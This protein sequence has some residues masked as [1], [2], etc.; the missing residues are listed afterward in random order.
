MWK[1][2]LKQVGRELLSTVVRESGIR[3]FLI[4][5]IKSKLTY[6]IT[7]KSNN[8][9][10]PCITDYLAENH[11]DKLSNIQPLFAMT[12]EEFDKTLIVKGKF[13]IWHNELPVLVVKS[14]A[15]EV[16]SDEV[17]SNNFQTI[18]LVTLSVHK[19]ALNEFI[20]SIYVD[21]LKNDVDGYI[22]TFSVN[23]YGEWVYVKRY[24]PMS[25]KN[26]IIDEKVKSKITNHLDQ[27][28]KMEQWYKN[29]GITYKTGALLHGPPRNGKSSFIAAVARKYG[30]NI[31][32]LSLTALENEDS[33]NK[34]FRTLN[35]YSNVI[36]VLEDIDSVWVGREPVKKDFNISFS[37]LLNCL[38]GVL[39]PENVIIMMTTN[40]IENLDSALIGPGRVDIKALF[41]N[42]DKELAEAYVSNFFET[43]VTLENYSFGNPVGWLQ[44]KC[45]EYKED[46]NGLLD[47]I[48]SYEYQNE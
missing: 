45:I 35:Q 2:I 16:N 21:S 5:N 36:L 44:N 41:D 29:R 10:Y 9:L 7:A 15:D 13:L 42:P 34:A 37:A 11:K 12:N 24:K 4:D 26:V 1:K 23:K 32:Y 38:N 31:H 33:L 14:D 8:H 3:E 19:N 39:D 40:Y 28:I 27:W 30:K 17:P 48:N 22:T 6:T 46:L 47:Y 20:K 43:S 25:I 18:K